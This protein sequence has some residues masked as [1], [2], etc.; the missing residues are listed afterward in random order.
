MNYAKTY[1]HLIPQKSLGH[2]SP[3][4]AMKLWQQTSPHL[5]KQAVYEQAGLD[6]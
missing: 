5:F 6:N 4:Q 1:N 3:I 2:K